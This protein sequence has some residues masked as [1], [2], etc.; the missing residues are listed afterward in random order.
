MLWGEH[1]VVSEV[2]VGVFGGD[3]ILAMIVESIQRFYVPE[4]GLISIGWRL[5]RWFVGNAFFDGST[6]W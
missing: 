1:V 2:V 3:K 5:E 4:R 6:V